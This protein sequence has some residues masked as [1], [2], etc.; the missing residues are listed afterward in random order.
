M[1]LQTLAESLNHLV[2]PLPMPLP[3]LPI[4]H[5]SLNQNGSSDPEKTFETAT[6][7]VAVVN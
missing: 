3:V 5:G 7:S 2:L 6:G 1:Y 4:K